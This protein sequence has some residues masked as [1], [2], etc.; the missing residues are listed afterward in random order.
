MRSSESFSHING[1]VP[2]A[3]RALSNLDGITTY[4]EVYGVRH[5]LAAYNTSL[6]H[7]SR[8]ILKT[9]DALVAAR[10]APPSSDTNQRGWEEALLEATDH[11]LDSLME[12]LDDCGDIIRSFFPNAES[13][14]YRT[15]FGEYKRS[16]EPYRKHIGNVVNYIKHNQGRLRLIN[17]TWPADRCF[18][19]FVEGPDDKGALGPAPS[20]HKPSNTAFSYNRDIPFHLCNVFSVGARLASALRSIDKRIVSSQPGMASPETDLAKA[21][22]GASALPRIYFVDEIKKDVPLIR[23]HGDGLAIEYPS[24]KKARS[25]PNGSRISGSFE[26]DGFT[27]TFRLPY[28]APPDEIR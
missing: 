27:R 5:P 19:Y 12:H 2:K 1:A 28:M 11:M 21:L 6:A 10:A 4:Q 16:V 23:L 3:A 17:V 18:G 9:L 15:V 22:R 14:Q 20:I 13:K 7:V 24:V 26:G 8:R 25:P